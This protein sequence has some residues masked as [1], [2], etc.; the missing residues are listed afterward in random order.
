MIIMEKK[1]SEYCKP[2]TREFWQNV[3]FYYRTHI[4][5]GII[6][7]ILIGYTINEISAKKDPDIAFM[8]V[9]T[10]TLADDT[11]AQV[12]FEKYTTD[13]NGDGTVYP[14]VLNI[15]L[16]N[17]DDIQYNSAMIQ[18]ADLTIA[19]DETPLILLAD[20][21]NIN[22]YIEMEAFAPIDE[23]LEK[24]G[25]EESKILRNKENN[26]ICVDVTDSNF[27]KQI[28]Y[29][30]TDKVYLG[31]QFKRENKKSDQEYLKLYAEAERMFEFILND[32]F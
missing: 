7:L 17:G 4:I 22:R 31:I 1:F 28:G 24:H 21:D 26:A 14:H 2:N 19:A 13:V 11:S 3:W 27:V 12:F 30:G 16:G 20:E 10:Q 32:S 25:T 5:A 8:Y 6:I 9:G 18:K 29:L 23:Y 15:A